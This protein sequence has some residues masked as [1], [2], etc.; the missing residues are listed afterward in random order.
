M[1]ADLH[2]RSRTAEQRS[3]QIREQ[4]VALSRQ[5]V[6]EREIAMALSGF[7]PVWEALTPR[8]QTRVVQLLVERV[9]YDGSNG[10]IGR[11]IARRAVCRD[12]RYGS[13]RAALEHPRRG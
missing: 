11:T 2:E 13:E 7:A 8:E 4:V 6:D 3:T 10:R 5:I 12:R 9:D 1:L